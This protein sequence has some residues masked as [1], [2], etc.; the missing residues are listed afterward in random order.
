MNK[1]LCFIFIGLGVGGCANGPTAIPDAQ[2]PAAVLY[3]EKCAACHALPHPKRNTVN[4][5]RHLVTLMEQ[6]MA[7][8]NMLALSAKEKETIMRYLQSNAR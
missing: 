3:A 6:R 7:E 1:I 4:E 2:S 8:R 5:W